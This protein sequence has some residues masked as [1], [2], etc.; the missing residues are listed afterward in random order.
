MMAARAEAAP[1]RA[2]LARVCGSADNDHALADATSNGYMQTLKS[3][4]ALA[5]HLIVLEFVEHTN[6]R[7]QSCD[8]R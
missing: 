7:T 2:D 6:S 5:A 8:C 1:L 4:L 3:T